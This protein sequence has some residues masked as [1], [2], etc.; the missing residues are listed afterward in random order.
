MTV[1][2]DCSSEH[3]SHLH[4]RSHLDVVLHVPGW[5]QGHRAGELEAARLRL[6]QGVDHLHITVQYST[7]QYST[8]DHH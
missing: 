6:V 3:Y 4:H 8:A 1:S 7:V 2:A 5:Q